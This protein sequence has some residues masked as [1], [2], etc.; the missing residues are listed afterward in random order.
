MIAVA[1]PSPPPNGGPAVMLT[2]VI[3]TAAIK[4]IMRHKK[5]P[6]Y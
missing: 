5:Q 4:F 3:M 2:F 6:C 1:C